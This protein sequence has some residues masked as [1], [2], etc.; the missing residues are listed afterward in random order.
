MN[1]TTRPA[2]RSR[3]RRREKVRMVSIPVERPER[4]VRILMRSCEQRDLVK[5]CSEL[6]FTL[7][8]IGA[9]NN[10]ANAMREMLVDALGLQGDLFDMGPPQ[11]VPTRVI[12]STSA[13]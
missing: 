7:H 11:H 8:R 1:G 2:P 10:W 4:A 5:L 9:I 3:T 13:R 12:R 6:G